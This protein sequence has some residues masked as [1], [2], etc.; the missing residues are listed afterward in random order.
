MEKN[1]SMLIIGAVSTV[2]LLA[3]LATLA[4]FYFNASSQ[5]KT[6]RI[7]TNEGTQEEKKVIHMIGHWKGEDLREDFVLETIREYETR[8]PD[9]KI[10]L[11]WNIDFPGVRAGA[12]EAMVDQLKSGSTT[13][14]V[15]W[16]E[17]FYYQL[18]AD[19]VNDPQWAKNH[20]VDFETV[21]GFIESQKPFIISDPQFRN[22]MNGVITG[23]YIEGFYQPFFYNKVLA[24]QIGLTI[25][26][27]D[28]TAEDLIGYV[29]Q[30]DAYNKEHGTD[31]P[32]FYEA[33]DIN[34]GIG[35]GP[36]TWNIFQSLFRSEFPDLEDLKT[37]V[38]TPEKDA[39]LKKTLATL[40]EIGQYRPLIDDFENLEWFGTRNYVLEN[41][42]V[43]T[44][45]GA[46]WMYS[47]WRGIDKQKTLNMVPVEMPVY[48]PVSHYIG[49]YNPMF[50]VMK[51]SPVRDEAVDF[52]M[53]FSKPATA[54]KWVR[55]AKAPSGIKGNLTDSGNDSENADQYDRFISHITEKYG[56]NVYDTKTVDYILGRKY[57]DLSPKFYRHI[58]AVMNGDITAEEAYDLIMQDVAKFDSTNQ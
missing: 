23:P 4:Y 26:E 13:W 41:K 39:A 49:G 15:I 14:D 1:K 18:I 47:H 12:F 38:M 22:H 28:M 9:V 42:A 54:E 50:A 3:L 44:A 7:T 8:N 53:E 34:G 55:Y 6:K 45:A 58:T 2:L 32:A 52:L 33:G 10:D 43:F 57:K 24:D 20:L 29:R 46:S 5:S 51:N 48:Q 19:E 35:Y 36:T 31:I 21:P 16:L 17:P 27:R 30:I 37:T 25:K 56:G 40:E 11:K